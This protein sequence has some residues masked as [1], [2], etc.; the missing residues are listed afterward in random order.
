MSR[1][2]KAAGHFRL[3]MVGKPIKN[4]LIDLKIV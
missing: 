3:A 1:N 2:P 4:K